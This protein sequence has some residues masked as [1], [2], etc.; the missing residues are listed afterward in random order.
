MSFWNR[1]WSLHLL[2]LIFYSRLLRIIELILL[3]FHICIWIFIRI[4]VIYARLSFLNNL[5]VRFGRNWE[6]FEKAYS[7]W[8]YYLVI[9][10]LWEKLVYQL[11][12]CLI[13]NIYYLPIRDSNFYS[14]ELLSEGPFNFL[15]SLIDETYDCFCIYCLKFKRIKVFLMEYS[16]VS[17]ELM[18]RLLI[19]LFHKRI[20]AFTLFCFIYMPLITLFE[21]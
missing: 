4:E 9:L 3:L 17:I 2:W 6:K 1:Y 10:A 21:I 5:L 14:K 8:E 16:M 15:K 20:S 12:A 18:N 19:S 11:F 7:L 13:G